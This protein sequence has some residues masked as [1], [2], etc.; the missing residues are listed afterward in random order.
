MSALA[1][2]R[3]RQ[4]DIGIASSPK[5]ING[6][7]Q[8][9]PLA[10]ASFD[11]VIA[12]FP[13]PYIFEKETVSEIGHVLKPGGLVIILLAAWFTGNNLLDKSAGLIYRITG[14]TPGT[15]Y[16]F[17]RFTTAFNEAGLDAQIQW[18]NLANNRLL[19]IV[20]KKKVKSSKPEIF[21]ERK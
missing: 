13:A 8:H 4:I 2:K 17:G 1:N 9:L 11:T 7:G 5:L 18:I 10:S 19:L 20:A 3:L 14:E 21:D 15:G 12:T 16:D 6:V